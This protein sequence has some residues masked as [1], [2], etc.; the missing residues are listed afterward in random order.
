MLNLVGARIPGRPAQS[1]YQE[2]VLLRLVNELGYSLLQRLYWHNPAKPPAPAEWVTVRRVRVT[3]AIEQIYWLSAGDPHAAKANN[4]HVL[5]P[6]G[7]AMARTL[8]RGGT[9][10]GRRPS[11]HTMSLTSFADDRGGSIPHNLLA[12]SNTASGDAYARYCRERDLPIHPARFPPDLA[13]ICIG[14]ATDPGDVVL[15]PCGGSQTTLAT[16]IAM[17][18]YAITSE[19]QREYVLGGHGRLAT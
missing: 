19:L 2:T 1:L 12:A 14:L 6:Y 9:N 11:G 8:R 18:R 4:H 16:A 7:A 15:D 10:L 5:R 13:K 17:G 3:L